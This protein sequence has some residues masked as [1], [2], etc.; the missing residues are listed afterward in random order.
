M[1]KLILCGIATSPKYD[2]ND[3]W[4]GAEISIDIEAEID[5][6]EKFGLHRVQ[7][8]LEVSQ[9]T[10]LMLNVYGHEEDY[11]KLLMGRV[12]RCLIK[13]NNKFDGLEKDI[14]STYKIIRQKVPVFFKKSIEHKL[15]SW[16]AETN[17]TD[18]CSED[19]IDR[20][21]KK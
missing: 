19:M 12:G 8:K 2:E 14:Y 10:A 18:E 11:I 6:G 15:Y 7:I 4:S 16:R 5:H 3:R 20:I 13:C 17:E 9:N 1:S 21:I